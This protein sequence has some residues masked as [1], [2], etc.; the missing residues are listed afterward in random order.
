MTKKEE[1]AMGKKGTRRRKK[2]K[3]KRVLTPSGDASR[4]TTSSFSPLG[5][6]SI[7]T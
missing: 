6:K 4:I 2:E 1:N 3:K 7:G 5:P